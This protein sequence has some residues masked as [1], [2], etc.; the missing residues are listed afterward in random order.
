VFLV[1]SSLCG[2]VG[3]SWL[4]VQYTI[5]IIAMITIITNH[6][7]ASQRS[8]PVPVL[9]AILNCREEQEIIINGERRNENEA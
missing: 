8:I 9:L 2:L 4:G 1:Q 6:C 3:W 5:I 7:I